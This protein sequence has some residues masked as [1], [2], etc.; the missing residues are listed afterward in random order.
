MGDSGCTTLL[1]SD[2]W[3]E[4]RF[5]DGVEELLTPQQAQHVY[6]CIY[7]NKPV[8]PLNSG[9][10]TSGAQNSPKPSGGPGTSS[11]VCTPEDS[12]SSTPSPMSDGSSN[13]C[14]ALCS[15]HEYGEEYLSLFHSLSKDSEAILGQ[16]PAEQ[17]EVQTTWSILT[18]Q[19]QFHLHL[20]TNV[21]CTTDPEPDPLMPD[22]DT[23]P[24]S[25]QLLDAD[26]ME[27]FDD[28]SPQFL[29]SSVFDPSSQI[30]ITCLGPIPGPLPKQICFKESF[31]FDGTCHLQGQLMNGAPLDILLD[32]GCTS[33]LMPKSFYDKNTCLHSLPKSKTTIKRIIVGSGQGLPVFFSIPVPFRIGDTL[34]E[35][36]TLVAEV[37]N[38][39]DFVIGL[40]EMFELEMH[41]DAQNQKVEHLNRSAPIVPRTTVTIPP[42]TEAFLILDVYFPEE[43]TGFA[44]CKW[45]YPPFG[46][47]TDKAKMF[48]N[49]IK[50]HVVNSS[51][52]TTLHYKKGHI[53]G[54]VDT[55]SMGYFK[56]PFKGLEKALSNNCV[57][58]EA[59]QVRK[60]VVDVLQA[61][62]Q[63][64]QEQRST[65]HTLNCDCPN[66]TDRH[67][68]LGT[69]ND[70][71]DPYPW[72]APDDERRLMSDEEIIDK[73]VDLQSSN[74]NRSQRRKVKQMLHTHKE[75][76]SLRDEIGDC[77]FMEI[78]IEVVDKTP[79]F[80][81]PFP[82]SEDDKPIIDKE[83]KRL[84]ALGILTENTTSHTSPVMLISRKVT[85]DKRPVTD[86]RELNCR[87][88]KRNIATPLLR[89]H[90][91]H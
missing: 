34:Y 79:F 62:Y 46:I 21:T 76:F 3:S 86:F 17:A 84:V 18:T 52:D 32:T 57:F 8:T 31:S 67:Q 10:P 37:T 85:S 43:L 51:R 6:N 63:I 30:G 80:I 70:R 42:G 4:V 64:Q 7:A 22:H 58:L 66:T 83:M 53:C 72:L 88:L 33:S 28:I 49:V 50:C 90:V 5:V 20:T 29:Q 12:S 23:T 14:E 69:R 59:N 78:D 82:I 81:R 60:S 27:K 89:C 40:K 44:C 15:T 55:R 45:L 73:F 9:H 65:H 91:T 54:I 77:P 13:I 38:Q 35:C 25:F 68:C 41:L 39:N 36:H 48:R 24:H 56:V 75:A 71:T 74:L 87:I 1:P 47:N 61:H 11:I 26:L 19:P 2:K 16:V